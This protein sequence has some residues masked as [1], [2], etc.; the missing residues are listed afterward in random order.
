MNRKL[1]LWLCVALVVLAGAVTIVHFVV[2]GS[3]MDVVGRFT[4][5]VYYYDDGSPAADPAIV[6]T[7]QNAENPKWFKVYYDDY[8]GDGYYWGKEWDESDDV[9][10]ED[11]NYHGNGWFRWRKEGKN[12]RE[13][14]QMEIGSA[15]VPKTWRVKTKSDSLLL[16]S[17]FV[18]NKCDRFGRVQEPVWE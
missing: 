7:W 14:H 18:K 4:N 5:D 8:D 1:I 2:P 12:L 6:G 9:F 16:F 13:E 11:L 10:E 17:T 15:I 3:R